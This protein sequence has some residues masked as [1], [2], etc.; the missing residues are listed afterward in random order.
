MRMAE[1]ERRDPGLAIAHYTIPYAKPG[2]TFGC[3][4]SY[5]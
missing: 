3:G 1:P 4:S 5:P 2:F